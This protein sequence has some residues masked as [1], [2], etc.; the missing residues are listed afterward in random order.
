M[1]FLL[2]LSMMRGFFQFS[3]EAEFTSPLHVHITLASDTD[4]EL[5]R[6]TTTVLKTC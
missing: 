3:P 5:Y 1:M 4:V 6:T 2:I